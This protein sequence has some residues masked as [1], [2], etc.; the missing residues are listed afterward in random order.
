MN[1]TKTYS[2]TVQI[3]YVLEHKI[4]FYAPYT[5]RKHMPVDTQQ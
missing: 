2:K 1:L 4:S 5:V 3:E